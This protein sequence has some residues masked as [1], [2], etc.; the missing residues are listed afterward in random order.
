MLLML[1]LSG[2]VSQMSPF[3]GDWEMMIVIVARRYTHLIIV[4]SFV[5]LE[6]VHVSLNMHLMD[7]GNSGGFIDHVSFLFVF[8]ESKSLTSG[9]L[10]FG[11]IREEE[12]EEEE[13]DDDD[14]DEEE[15][16]EEEEE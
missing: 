12:E 16:E 5:S 14:D 8:C 13:E 11:V 2:V 6:W 1:L 10:F 9:M 15:E 4:L 7:D 3:I